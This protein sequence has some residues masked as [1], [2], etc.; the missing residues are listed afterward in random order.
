MKGFPIIPCNLC[1]SQE[2]L[3]RASIKE[4][5]TQWD[6]QFPGRIE[7]MFR[8]MCNIVPSHLADEQLFDFKSLKTGFAHGIED[9][10]SILTLTTSNADKLEKQMAVQVVEKI[11]ITS[12]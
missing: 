11:E 1:G 6:K 10:S 12:L 4:M 8:A 2:N 5:L 7:S 9:E 3:Q